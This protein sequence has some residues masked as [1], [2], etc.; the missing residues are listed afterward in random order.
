[1]KNV[2]NLNVKIFA[3]GADKMGMASRRAVFKEPMG[4][5]GAIVPWNYPVEVTL[6]KLG[7]ILAT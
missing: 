3:D 1:M 6:N 7:P 4:V 2:E 5:V